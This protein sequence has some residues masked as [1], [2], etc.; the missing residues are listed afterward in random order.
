MQRDL[1]NSGSTLN[2]CF[3]INEG[4]GCGRLPGRR[5]YYSIAVQMILA[6]DIMDNDMLHVNTYPATSTAPTYFENCAVSDSGEVVRLPGTPKTI[7]RSFIVVSNNRKGGVVS[8]DCS[9]TLMYSTIDLNSTDEM[10]V[11]F[12]GDTGEILKTC[13]GKCILTMRMI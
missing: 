3:N 5:G 9:Q 4:K 10:D 12:V 8:Q 6:K 13:S 11:F 2:W 1:E 7:I